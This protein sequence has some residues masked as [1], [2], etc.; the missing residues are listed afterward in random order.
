MA[1]AGLCLSRKALVTPAR[2]AA[3]VCASLIVEWERLQHLL[4]VQQ[5][6]MV[7]FFSKKGMGC[8]C[9]VSADQECCT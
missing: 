1:V 6:V 2:G 8:T 3:P 4:D 5:S 7:C 9:S